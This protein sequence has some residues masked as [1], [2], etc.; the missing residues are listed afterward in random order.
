[1]ADPVVGSVLGGKYLVEGILG[2][3][4]MGIVVAARHIEL[5]QRVAIKCLLAHAQAVPEIVER[6]TRE[7]RAAAKIHGEH[8]ARVIDVGRFDDGTPF[9]VMEHL[10]GRDL[11][12]EL[13]NKGSL[14]VTE[15]VRYL[16]ETCEAL[17]QAHALRIVH[18]DLKPSNLFLAEQ[19]GRRAIVKVL[20][21]GIS[22]VID[23][24]GGALTKTASV[25]GTPYYMSPE[26]LLSSK[27]VDERSDIWA[28]G[29]ILYELLVGRPPFMAETAPEVVAQVL[30]NAPAP[31]T[32]LRPDVP[33]G[34]AEVI[35]RCMRSKVNERFANVAELAH[36]LVPF[37][38]RE[39]RES[40]L[41]IA[42]VLGVTGG[43][44]SMDPAMGAHAP[45]VAS[46]RST[47]PSAGGVA[48]AGTAHNLTFSAAD[49]PP[50][51]RKPVGAILAG[52][53]VLAA[54]AVAGA[55]ALHHPN[56][57][58]AAAAVGAAPDN[59]LSAQ[60]AAGLP[61]AAAP[62][63][64][65]PVDPP[66]SLPAPAIP[67]IPTAPTAAG[68]TAAHAG[69]K[70]AGVVAPV[71]APGVGAGAAAVAPP[72]AAVPASPPQAAPPSNPLDM[73]IK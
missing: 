58:P 71:H 6:F 44:G 4:G 3:G 27:S 64:L 62:V 11:A 55:V 14:P 42:R 10:K 24:S 38:A 43:E 40:A 33:P 21:F 28:L 63:G 54:I 45:T 59:A 19:P 2:Q 16:L 23:P 52:V 9:M 47:P 17:V 61:S 35:A 68:S 66:A 26:Q 8:V 25:M 29:I 67:A 36:A 5:D 22:K 31:I 46:V 65:A 30:Q 12:D 48:P 39:D 50:G 72:P 49:T 18:R 15:A 51:A 56:A 1:M 69:A 20:D 13:A 57:P 7:A 37:A 73:H 32:E 34:L 60:T 53:G 70:H 41:A